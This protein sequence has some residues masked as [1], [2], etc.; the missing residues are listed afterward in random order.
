[1]KGS[2][3]GLVAAT[4]ALILVLAGFG[5][6]PGVPAFFMPPPAPTQPA[7]VWNPV[8]PPPPSPG[9]YVI[10]GAEGLYGGYVTYGQAQYAAESCANANGVCT[11]TLGSPQ[12]QVILT[13]TS[14]QGCK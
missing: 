13:C 1:M 10:G 3:V 11:I 9:Y 4:G 14:G 6:I 12:G 7:A 8:P 5:Y 2:S